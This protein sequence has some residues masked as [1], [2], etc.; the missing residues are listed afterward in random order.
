MNLWGVALLA[1]SSLVV[2]DGWVELPS[3]TAKGFTVRVEKGVAM[4]VNF[5]A[6][7]PESW[8]RAS[9]LQVEPAEPNQRNQKTVLRMRERVSHG[10][11]RCPVSPNTDYQ[12]VLENLRSRRAVANVRVR[13]TI[14]AALPGVLEPSGRLPELRR[15]MVLLASLIYLTLIAAGPGRKLLR[16]ALR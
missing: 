6:R 9:I 13:V 12:I 4:E 7:D 11:L 1:T 5:E 2:Y 3:R 8:L 10:R 15:R 14:E 16:Q